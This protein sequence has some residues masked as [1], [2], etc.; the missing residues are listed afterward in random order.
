MRLSNFQ[1]GGAD[2]LVS[3]DMCAEGFDAP[4]LRVVAYL[5]TV[6][7]RSRFVQ[8]ITRAVRMCNIRAATET[9]PRDPSYVFAPADPLLMSYARSWSL[10]EPYRIQAQPQEVDAD[11]PLQS[12]AWRGPSLPLEAVNDGAGAVIRLRTPELPNFCIN[13]NFSVEKKMRR[14]AKSHTMLALQQAM[15]SLSGSQ[16]WTQH[17]NDESVLPPAGQQPESM[18]W[19][20]LSAMRTATP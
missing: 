15:W 4:R 3:I 12:G 19:T 14:C 5:T 8:G 7:T 6:V 2:W 17:L 13:E 10:S 16:S 11:D 9:V 20:A 1:E 18:L